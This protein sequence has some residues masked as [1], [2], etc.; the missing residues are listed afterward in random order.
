MKQTTENIGK[1]KRQKKDEANG[2]GKLLD[3]FYQETC[4]SETIPPNGNGKVLDNDCQETF[5]SENV[6]PKRKRDRVK[7]RIGNNK[8]RMNQHR[9]NTRDIMKQ[10]RENIG[11]PKRQKKDEVNGKGKLLDNF[12]QETCVS[13]TI[14]PNGNGK[15]L[16]NDCQETFVSENVLPKRKR[17]RVKERIGNNRERMNQHRKNTTDIIK[18]TRENIG[19]P[20]RQ[21]KDEVNGKGKLLDN[22]YQE[23]CV[24]E[25]IPPNGN[26]KM[27]DNDS[28][29]TFVS[30]NVLPKRKRDRVKETRGT[31][32]HRKKQHRKKDSVKY[33]QNAKNFKGKVSIINR[34]SNKTKMNIVSKWKCSQ[35][36]SL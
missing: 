29:E 4:V 24:S 19:R 3:N 23:T 30:E 16:D 36:A 32:K 18:Q 8:E 2:K 13:E 21:K 28:Q 26:G 9:K 1:P 35:M 20:K 10:T 31:D 14:P 7:E 11:R 25:T 27:L 6:L 17:D 15:V 34:C 5:V 22:L 33:K 12:Y